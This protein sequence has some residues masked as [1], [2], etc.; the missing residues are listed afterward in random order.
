MPRLHHV[1]HVGQGRG[2]QPQRQ[3][4]APGAQPVLAGGLEDG[5]AQDRAAAAHDVGSVRRGQ[6]EPAMARLH[7]I[8]DVLVS[9]DEDRAHGGLLVEH[10]GRAGQR[11]AAQRRGLVQDGDTVVRDRAVRITSSWARHCVHGHTPQRS[12]TGTLV[13][14]PRW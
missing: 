5:A 14:E 7:T 3:L 8:P 1:G 12:G 4:A 11:V 10:C 9:G 13:P 6:P 2:A